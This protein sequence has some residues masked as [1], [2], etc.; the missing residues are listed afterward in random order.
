MK[1]VNWGIL[2]FGKA[3]NS[4]I[5]SVINAKNSNLYAISSLSHYQNLISNKQSLN[6]NKVKIFQNYFKLLEDNNVEAVYIG[7]TNNLHSE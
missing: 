3:S 6:L 5:R 2:G 4:L 7:L 1:K